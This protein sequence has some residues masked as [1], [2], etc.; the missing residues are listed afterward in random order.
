[1]S[2]QVRMTC[3]VVRRAPGTSAQLKKTW[4][5]RAVQLLMDSDIAV[6][7]LAIAALKY[8]VA[9]PRAVLKVLEESRAR[10]V[11]V[12]V[13]ESTRSLLQ[14]SKRLSTNNLAPEAHPSSW[15]ALRGRVSEQPI[16]AVFLARNDAH[17]P[18]KSSYV[19]QR[20]AVGRVLHGMGASLRPLRIDAM[21][22]WSE[23]DELLEKGCRSG[24][25]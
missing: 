3:G 20:R 7:T 16:L 4:G 23:V 2:G 10:F 6:R 25:R 17:W 19:V 13:A 11:N 9:D 5:R 8:V 22:A 1:M 15:A 14:T 12:E 21:S 24:Q 18:I